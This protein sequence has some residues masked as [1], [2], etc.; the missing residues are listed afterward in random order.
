MIAERI[1]IYWQLGSS[2]KVGIV[3]TEI[4]GGQYQ[5]EHM[6]GG[7]REGRPVGVTQEAGGGKEGART[8]SPMV[9]GQQGL[10]REGAHQVD[11]PSVHAHGAGGGSAGASTSLP[12]DRGAGERCEAKQG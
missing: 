4:T 11:R 8:G 2:P 1:Q 5:A 7:P 9:G 10:L 12:L 3:G 6:D